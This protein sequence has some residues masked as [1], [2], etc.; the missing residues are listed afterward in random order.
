MEENRTNKKQMIINNI[1]IAIIILIIAIFFLPISNEKKQ[2]NEIDKTKT[3]I[4][5]IAKR[6]NIR[7]KP[8]IY[9]EDIGDVYANEIYTV[10]E[11]VDNEEAY[12]YK[13]TTANN[14]TGYIASDPNNEYVEVISGLIDRTPPEISCSKN[15]L[16]FVNG[17]V[18]FDDIKCIDNDKGCTLSYDNSNSSYI[19]FIAQDESG[20]QSTLSV[21][22]YN[23]YN[24]NETYYE[25]N[26]NLN[27]TFMQYEVDNGVLIKAKYELN[28]TIS[29]DNKSINYI[30]IM[31]LFDE[32]FNELK[33][34]PIKY[35][36]YPLE[37]TCINNADMTL[38]E[39]YL[40][41]DLLKGNTICINYYFDNTDNRI[42]YFAFGFS[43]VENY[44]KD[45]NY[46]ASYYSRY[47]IYKN[48][49]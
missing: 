10:I 4:K 7:Q 11:H 39:E 30:P 23:V 42:N 3:Q 18:T 25:T 32:N 43:G 1:I 24:T 6:I 41:Q 40:N 35:N 22:Y 49:N 2:S 37:D 26:K 45:E 36:N 21:K 47:Y 15:F 19:N 29:K 33:L 34:L 17:E 44:N 8:T 14:I 46:L 28:N 31:T 5:I 13:I 12:W 20:N 48:Q 38:K 27:A 16:I 9:S